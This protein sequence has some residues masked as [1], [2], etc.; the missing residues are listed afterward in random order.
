MDEEEEIEAIVAAMRRGEPGASDRLMPLV[1]DRLRRIAA[2]H[3]GGDARV[4]TMQPTAVVHEAYMR[5]QRIDHETWEGRAHFMAVASQAIRHVLV[6]AA[7]RRNAAKRGKNARG[8]TLVEGLAVAPDRNRYD[9]L[10]LDR[11]L[12]ELSLLKE[13]CTR[14]VEL[15]FFGGMTVDETA[16]ALACSPTTVKADWAIAKVWLARRL[17]PQDG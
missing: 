12:E 17:A 6:D 10:D 2:S 9:V 1:Y 15:R 4:L 14:V 5:L 7:R 13:R 11:A 8:L 16:E 3:M